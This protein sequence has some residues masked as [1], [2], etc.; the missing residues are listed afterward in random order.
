MRRGWAAIGLVVVLA[1]GAGGYALA[2]SGGGTSDYAGGQ[3]TGV[4]PTA[5]GLPLIGASATIGASDMP[6]AVRSYHDS[7]QYDKDLAAV[8]GAARA[9][10]DRRVAGNGASSR[11]CKISYRRTRHRQNHHLVY[12]RF[13]HCKTAKTKVRKLAIVLDID[14]TALSNYTGLVASG[15]SADGTVVPAVTGTGTA[16][17]PTLELYRDARSHGVAVFFITGRP[18]QIQSITEQNLKSQGYSQGWDGL[19]MKPSSA[20]TEAFKAAQRAKI[21]QQGYDI[22]VNMG[23]QESDLD[24]GHADRDFKLPNPFYFIPD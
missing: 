23:D 16:I 12:R 22:A 7:G 24:G 9:Y 21:E 10:L 19:A 4:R 2:Q 8:G 17:Q 6:S 14:E 13:K 15:F 11:T 1:T 3:E 5:V 18:S 20:G